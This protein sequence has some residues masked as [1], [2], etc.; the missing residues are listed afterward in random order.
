MRAGRGRDSQGRDLSERRQGSA[1]QVHRQLRDGTSDHHVINMFVIVQ[2]SFP[3]LGPSCELHHNPTSYRAFSSTI[4]EQ[5]QV[6]TRLLVT[7]VRTD[8]DEQFLNTVI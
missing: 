4:R 7:S 5:K 3:L 6:L 2:L 1:A 8:R